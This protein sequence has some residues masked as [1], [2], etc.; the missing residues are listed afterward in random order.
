MDNG[1]AL[2][3][4]SLGSC[5]PAFYCLQSSKEGTSL[6]ISD[7]LTPYSSLRIL[8]STLALQLQLSSTQGYNWTVSLDQGESYILPLF[9]A[10]TGSL[11]SGTVRSDECLVGSQSREARQTPL[12]WDDSTI[13]QQIWQMSL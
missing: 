13:T 7:L 11:G 9:F 5:N 2:V 4:W 10:C 3:A 1:F 12:P 8:F 6:F